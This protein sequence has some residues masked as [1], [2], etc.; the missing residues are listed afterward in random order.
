MVPLIRVSDPAQRSREVAQ[1][2]R[3]LIEIRRF[4]DAAAMI[5]AELARGD[6][7]HLWCRCRSP[8][9]AWVSWEDSLAAARRAVVL[10][11]GNEWGYRLQGI[12]LHGL[13]RHE[14]GLAAL[15]AAVQLAPNAAAPWTDLAEGESGARDTPR[16][17]ASSRSGGGAPRLREGGY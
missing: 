6:D 13:G 17:P 14:E 4:A 10:R 8:G 3:A 7:W 15:K 5:A 11:P 16:R 12:A 9:F 2:A 1:R